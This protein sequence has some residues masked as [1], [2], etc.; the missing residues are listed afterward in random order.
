MPEDGAQVA[1]R[2]SFSAAGFL[3]MAFVVVGLAGIFATYAAPVP[4]GRALAREAVLDQVLAASVAPDAQA[5]LAALR[6]A[7][8]ESAGAVLS[9]P[10]TLA[11]RVARERERMRA[12][13]EQEAADLGARLRL[14]IGVVTFA[15]A[16]FGLAMLGVG[17]SEP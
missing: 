11:E 6:P 12:R 2:P 16:L 10:G 9:G 13:S 4:F 7:L 8:G 14:L 17:R 3:A 15:A 1:G 5:R